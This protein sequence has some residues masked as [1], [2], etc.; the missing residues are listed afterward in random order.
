MVQGQR[1]PLLSDYFWECVNQY[2]GLRSK[3]VNFAK[4]CVVCSG[5]AKGTERCTAHP[6]QTL[7]HELVTVHSSLDRGIILLAV[8]QP[9]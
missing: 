4:K 9:S 8:L 5:R 6:V 1:L 7:Q 3:G 2:A